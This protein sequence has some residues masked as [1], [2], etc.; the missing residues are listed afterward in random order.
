MTSFSKTIGM[1][2]ID[3]SKWTTEE[4]KTLIKLGE[5]IIGQRE[6]S[7]YSQYCGNPSHNPPMLIYIPPNEKHI[8]TCPGCGNQIIMYGSNTT[9]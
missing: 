6:N 2:G 4:I 7:S 8:H 3:L 1:Y 5:S 9:C